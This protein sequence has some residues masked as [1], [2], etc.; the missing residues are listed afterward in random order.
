MILKSRQH[1]YQTGRWAEQFALQYLV[2]K[3]LTLLGSNF[4]SKLGEIDLIMQDKNIICFIEVRYRL[5]NHFQTASESITAKKCQRIILASQ[6]YLI[7]NRQ[8]TKM[9]CRFDVVALCGKQEDPEIEWIK[10][11]FQA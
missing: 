5:N 10:D 8:A 7:E 6:Q 3:N 4:R 9:D 2:N 11:A 1:A